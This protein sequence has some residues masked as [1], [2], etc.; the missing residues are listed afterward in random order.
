M[1]V[2]LS[3]AMHTGNMVQWASYVKN[4]PYKGDSS[5]GSK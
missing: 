5:Y 1:S 3:A 4:N 2:F